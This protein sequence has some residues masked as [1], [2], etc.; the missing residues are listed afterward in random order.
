MERE[1]TESMEKIVK[2]SEAEWKVMS[3]LWEV[4]VLN[5]FTILGEGKEGQPALCLL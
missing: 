4:S 3:L 2:L 1:G 5:M